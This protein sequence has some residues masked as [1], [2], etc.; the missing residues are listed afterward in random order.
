LLQA[1]LALFEELGAGLWAEQARADIAR[2]GG[3]RARNGQ[4]Q[5]TPTERQIAE[6]AAAGRA[7]RKLTPNA[8]FQAARSPPNRE[9]TQASPVP[10]ASSG[11]AHAVTVR[12]R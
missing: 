7:N 11:S 3:R 4:D 1:A 12:V 8:A 9:E 2:L 10:T 5:L 6:L